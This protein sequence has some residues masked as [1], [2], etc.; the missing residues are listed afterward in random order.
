MKGYELVFKSKKDRLYQRLMAEKKKIRE[1]MNRRA[2]K[3]NIKDWDATLK[4]Y[5]KQLEKKLER[6][7]MKAIDLAKKE[8][9]ENLIKIISHGFDPK[10]SFRGNPSTHNP[11][12]K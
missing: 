12:V 8:Q 11:R 2:Q 7:E 5:S 4:F 9:A 6:A 1:A 3:E 10:T